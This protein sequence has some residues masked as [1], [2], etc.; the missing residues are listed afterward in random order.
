MVKFRR[1]VA[2]SLPHLLLY[3][4]QNLLKSNAILR[5]AAINIDKK[6][7]DG[8]VEPF[9][10][11]ASQATFGANPPM[12]VENNPPLI[13]QF[14]PDNDSLLC[15]EADGS[16]DYSQP[17][18]GQTDTV[19]L[20]PRGKCTFERKALSAQRLGASGIIIYGTL[21][22]R[23]SLNTTNP[24]I[25]Y[26]TDRSDYDCDRA[27]ASIS[28]LALSFD[29]PPYNSKVN[30]A[31]LS[32]SASSGNLCAV[33][34]DRFEE[35][36]PS[37]RCLLTGEVEV[38][39][40]G[41]VRQ[42]QQQPEGSNSMMKS[43][44][45]WDLPIWLY[46]DSELQQDA[47]IETVT[48]PAF[49]VT[50]E[51]GDQIKDVI[52]TTG[53]FST[54]TMYRR[55]APEYNLSGLV[56]WALGVCVAA[57]AAYLSASDYRNARK[58]L[59]LA[60]D[61]QDTNSHG[62]GNDI[63]SA[64]S[65][66]QSTLRNRSN[67]PDTRALFLEENNEQ[68]L[69]VHRNGYERVG[70]PAQQN[71]E[72]T[73]E[74][75]EA[76]AIGFVFFSAA[77]LLTLFYFKIYSFVKVMYGFSCC[78]AMVT[79]IF[80]PLY[81]RIFRKLHVRN[82]VAF[83]TE[84]F[85]IGTVTYATL[86]AALTSYSLGAVWMYISFT[87]H[88]PDNI[89]FFWIMQ[90]V[91]GACVCITFLSV[92]KLNSIKVAIMLLIAA[93]FY[94]IFFVFVTPYITKGGKSIMIDVA[95]SGGPPKADP[96][97]CEKYPNDEDCQGGDLL[98]MLLT[99]PR[100]FDYAGGSSLLGLGDIVLP[101]LLLSFGARYDEAKRF[102][103]AQRGGGGMVARGNNQEI[104]PESNGRYF[105]PLVVAYAVGLLMAN[106]AVYLMQ[107]GQP[108]LLYLV[109][110]CL[111]TICFLGWRRN[112]LSEMWKTP[113]VLATSDELLYR[114]EAAGGVEYNGDEERDGGEA[115][116]SSTTENELL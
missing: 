56:I 6:H 59:E 28:S 4:S 58:K 1:T 5:T 15:N 76:H 27:S 43:C 30:D 94:D 23:Y 10:L 50:I 107:M 52:S 87:V 24:E 82:S 16:A 74:L 96:S 34:N 112:E 116:H 71:T 2:T 98:P 111:G 79:V 115:T 8:S 39:G 13:P 84:T 73:L 3:L 99:I 21:A 47:S 31:V 42:L 63:R 72:E 44:C 7:A 86:L 19:W 67:S 92:I 64:S 100:L 33:G 106:S 46:S 68:Q 26:P 102:I 80:R 17:R 49:Y 11:L 93:F 41:R 20:V 109:P 35:M 25:I 55:Y 69:D 113:K 81:S 70:T 40:R 45:A 57:L 36:C 54:I 38:I 85:E 89:T 114:E 97:W 22:S 78:N 110:C 60:R 53:T 14:P 95:T 29:P 18:T 88:H 104:C 12:S 105:I 37:Q 108:A 101:G 9:T 65:N 83:T 75:T 66:N 103:G 32:G 61:A 77:G 51:Q 48:I 90:D 62:K 91:M